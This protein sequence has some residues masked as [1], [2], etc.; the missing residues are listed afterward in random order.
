LG[1][2][3]LATSLPEPYQQ[4]LHLVKEEQLPLWKAE[5]TFFS[6]SHAEV[7]GYLLSLWGL[8]NPIVE[9]V[10]YHH[11]PSDSPNRSLSPVVAVHAANALIHERQADL[12]HQEFGG[13][14][15]DYVLSLGLGEQVENWRDECAGV[16]KPQPVESNRAEMVAA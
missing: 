9:G 6:C 12:Q 3:V 4:A 5:Q 2:L 8:P 13:L 14:D 10:A 7:A 11:R 15:L 16:F 1:K